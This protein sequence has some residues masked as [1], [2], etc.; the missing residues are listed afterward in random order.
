MRHVAIT[1]F[2][3]VC[4]SPLVAEDV[5][6]PESEQ[7]L[8]DGLDDLADGMRRLFEGFQSDVAPLME[9]LAD[10]LKGLGD[11]H[12]PEVLPNGDI[13]IRR[14][15]AEDAAPKAEPDAEGAIDI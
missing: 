7:E 12:P 6:R 13:I 14:K 2:L 5:P 11:Y 3:M 1:L 4:A 8:F 9:D 15:R 10:R